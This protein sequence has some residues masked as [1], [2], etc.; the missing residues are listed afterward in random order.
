MYM[1]SWII[2]SQNKIEWCSK[3]NKLDSAKLIHISWPM[4]VTGNNMAKELNLRLWQRAN[5]IEVR[6]TFDAFATCTAPWDLHGLLFPLARC[7]WCFTLHN[8]Y[9]TN[10]VFSCSW[11]HQALQKHKFLFLSSIIFLHWFQVR[12][13]VCCDFLHEFYC[14]LCSLLTIV[15]PRNATWHQVECRFSLSWSRVLPLSY[16]FQGVFPDCDLIILQFS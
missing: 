1:L 15:Q 12:H 16:F 2:V 3:K 6:T 11:I 13:V 10:V 5:W 9:M 4:T 8:K 14:K 7:H